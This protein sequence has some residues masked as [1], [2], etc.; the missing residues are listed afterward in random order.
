MVGELGS[1]QRRGLRS[2]I[3][4]AV[5]G[6]AVGVVVLWIGSTVVNCDGDGGTCLRRGFLGLASLVVLAP[7]VAWVVLRL[8][9]VESAFAVAI[10]G[11]VA[12]QV[13]GSVAR[14]SLTGPPVY[15]VVLAALMMIG[16]GASAALLAFAP[17]PVLRVLTFVGAFLFI[18]AILAF[19]LVAMVLIPDLSVAS[20]LE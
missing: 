6:A 11:T 7:A 15:A 13:L 3:A 12:S 1:A 2:A 14:L 20:G 4:G 16:Y 8:F 18:V 9:R 19:L 17:P 5:A 10:C